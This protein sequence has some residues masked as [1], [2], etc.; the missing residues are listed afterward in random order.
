MQL[1]ALIIDSFRHAMDRK[2]FWVMIAISTAI[3]GAFALIGTTDTGGL[4]IMGKWTIVEQGGHAIKALILT[5]M[6]C[7]YYIGGIGI[8]LALIATAGVIPGFLEQG[9]VDVVLSK[10]ISR[11]K[12]FLGKYVGSMAF[13]ALQAA[14]FVVVTFFVVGI[15]WEIWLWG[16]F[17]AIPLIILL[18]SY[19]YA[20]CALFG[21][22]TRSS[23]ASLLLTILVWVGLFAIQVAYGYTQISHPFNPRTNEPMITG[24]WAKASVTLQTVIP[25]T[26]HI[27]YIAQDLT[28]AASMLDVVAPPEGMT[29]EQMQSYRKLEDVN[30]PWSIGTSLACESVVVMVAIFFFSRRDY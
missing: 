7:D 2:L 20:F 4:S 23:L 22:L 10:P 17:W 9:G 8:I 13:T 3:A 29:K 25:K 28:G 27:T 14:Y 5:K 26:Q 12:L 19:L 21:V 15:R 1:T 11:P 24:R 6:V 18:F 30:I 16:Y